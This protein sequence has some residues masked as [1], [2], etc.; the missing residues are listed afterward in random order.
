MNNIRLINQF[1][2]K[3]FLTKYGMR[4]RFSLN[5]IFSK[6]FV[7]RSRNDVE[8]DPTHVGGKNFRYPSDE[9]RRNFCYP[10][11]EGAGGGYSSNVVKRGLL[12]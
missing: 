2:T 12:W 1:L 11:L 7:L 3:T 10:P 5:V 4:M 8:T 6:C 9:G